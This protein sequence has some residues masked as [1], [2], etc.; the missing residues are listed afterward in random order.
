[1]EIGN[2]SRIV[3]RIARVAGILV[4]ERTRFTIGSRVGIGKDQSPHLGRI[5]KD[6]SPNLVGIGRG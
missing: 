4:V 6:Q 2:A 5:G 1:M 3:R